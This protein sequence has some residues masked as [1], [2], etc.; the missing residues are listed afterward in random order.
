MADVSLAML[1]GAVMEFC[2]DAIVSEQADGNIVIV[3]NMNLD[4]KG[5]LSPFE[6]EFD[7]AI[8]D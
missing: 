7:K 4:Y 8:D 3:T 1:M 5:I 2:P 6:N